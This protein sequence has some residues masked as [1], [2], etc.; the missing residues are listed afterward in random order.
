MAAAPEPRAWGKTARIR[1]AGNCRKLQQHSTRFTGAHR[2]VET[3]EGRSGARGASGEH[4]QARSHARLSRRPGGRAHGSG[5]RP[6]AVALRLRATSRRP[7]RC[8]A[9]HPEP[10]CRGASVRIP[11]RLAA[12]PLRRERGLPPPRATRPLTSSCGGRTWEASCR[13]DSASSHQSFLRKKTP[14][15]PA[16]KEV[17]AR[18]GLPTKL[19]EVAENPAV[20][21]LP[22]SGR[23]DL[24]SGP[25][26]PQTVS[27]TWRGVA[28]RGGKWLHCWAS[29][30]TQVDKAH[31]FVRPFQDVWA[32]IGHRAGVPGVEPR[33]LV[34]RVVPEASGW[35][36]V[37]PGAAA[38]GQRAHPKSTQSQT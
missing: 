16:K 5:A 35:V 15:R 26:V 37:H 22:R 1:I 23:R 30:S 3:S 29:V 21:G 19:T 7:G 36:G 8:C 6:Q 31:V 25:L 20:A 12:A 11:V 28:G 17:A 33:R 10:C 38:C 18:V 32:L 13:Q 4:V 14:F 34:P 2:A 27:A 24:N 9:L